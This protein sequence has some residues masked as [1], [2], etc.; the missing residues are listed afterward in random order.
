MII[1]AL[2]ASMYA[3]AAN[4]NN[5]VIAD[6]ALSHVGETYGDCWPFVRDMIYQASGGTQDISAAA[7]GGDYFAHLSNAGGTRVSSLGSLIKG[8]VVQEG[9]YGGHTFIIV[10]LVSGSTF[11]VVDSNHDWMGTVMH[12]HKAVTLDSD[13]QAFRFGSASSNSW[14]GVGNTK[15]IGT[16][17][18]TAGQSMY[19][20]QYIVSGNVQ[21]VLMM[22]SDGNLVLY[23]NKSAVWSSHTAN[24]GANRVVMQSDGNL[25]IYTSGGS[26]VWSSRT[27]GKGSSYAVMQADGNFVVY[28][29]TGSA[30]WQSD[31]G[32][33]GTYVNSGV[34]RLN[35]N[36]TTIISNSYLRSADKRYALLLQPDGNVV[37][38]SAG[39]HVLWTSHT[40]GS[41]AAFLTLQGDG[42]LVLKTAGGT[43]IWN[44]QTGGRGASSAIM[45]TDGN[46]VIYNS[47]GQW[48]WQSWTGGKI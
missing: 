4:Y 22:Q 29:S 39:Y 43:V 18:L 8:D 11:D 13:D 20:G 32:G 28:T 44:S 41:N 16:D 36:T 3:R 46:F 17:K 45:Q 34:D 30:T 1:A 2:G 14:S 5:A 23:H 6:K 9:Q 33:H 12:Y 15:Y 24:I 35:N 7:G 25:V 26:A 37:L 31:T 10:G 47:A 19:A 42:N 27:S 40:S 48:T 21:H 38:F